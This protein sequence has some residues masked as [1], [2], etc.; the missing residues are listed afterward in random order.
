MSQSLVNIYIH[1]IFSTKK[2]EE[3]LCDKLIRKEMYKYIASILHTYN[4]SAIAIGGTKDHIHIL[5]QLNKN[6]MLTK[7][8]A[9]IKKSSTKW[10]KNKYKQF[11]EFH[12][13]NGYGA[14]SVSHSNIDRVCGYIRNQEKHHKKFS[15]Q[16]ELRKLFQELGIN[17][18]ERYL[19]D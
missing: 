12:W 13:Q 18:D 2:R 17:Y 6:N 16:D 11:A 14:F 1:V 9:E 15:F 3:F 7:I 19:W 5:M 8:I 10:V 4:S